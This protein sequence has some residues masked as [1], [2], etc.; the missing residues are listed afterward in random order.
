MQALLGLVRGACECMRT[1]T[2]THAHTHM[3]T[4][5]HAVIVTWMGLSLPSE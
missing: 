5:T 2:H 1:H 3:H 4:H